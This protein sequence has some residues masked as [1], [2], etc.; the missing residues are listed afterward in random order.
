MEDGDSDEPADPSMTTVSHHV[1]ED[2]A[3]K[4]V[5]SIAMIEVSDTHLPLLSSNFMWTEKLR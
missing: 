2:D 4:P 3:G 1:F 5:F